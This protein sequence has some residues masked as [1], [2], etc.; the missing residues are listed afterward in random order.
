M[1]KNKDNKKFSKT[2]VVLSVV[3]V[4]LVSVFFFILFYPKINRYHTLHQRYELYGGMTDEL[5]DSELYGDLQSGKP[6]CFLGDSITAGLT[7][8]GVPW[9]QPMVPYIKGEISN[10]S[11]SGWQVKNLI[12][13]LDNIPVADIYI[14]AIGINDILF[15]DT[16]TAS[17]T[18][19]DFVRNTDKLATLIKNKSK[20]AKIYYVSPWPF[21]DLSED[22]YIRGDEFRKAMK[23]Y[24]E[25][26]D[27]IY[28]DADPIIAA[29]LEAEGSEKY[30]Y[31]QFHPNAPDGIGLFSYA[32][33][34]AACENR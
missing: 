14:I 13:N 26:T 1:D 22:Y 10:Y 7:T 31:N 33:F 16:A 8:N 12:I 27:C 25:R 21:V 28:I 18:A 6:V 19:D 11:V 9:Y 4:L 30:M 32:V 17:L 23:D 20:G 2:A 15:T 24:C 34:K 3:L 29:V 5:K